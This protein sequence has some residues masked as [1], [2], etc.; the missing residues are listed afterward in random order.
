H[1]REESPRRDA[2]D[3]LEAVGDEVVNAEIAHQRLDGKIE[4]A[5]DDDLAQSEASRL[6]DQL[7]RA[8][9]EAG[10]E[11]VLE[12][13]LREEAQAVFRLALVAAEEDVVEDH[14]AVGVG[15]G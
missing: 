7:N 12:K 9:E 6:L 4:R 5:G 1:G 15:D 8:G 2:V 3:E 13:L 14:T 11:D 10:L